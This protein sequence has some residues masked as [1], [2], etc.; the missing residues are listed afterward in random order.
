MISRLPK[1]VEYGA[2]LLAALAGTVNVIGLLGFEHQAVSHLS[3]MVTR[4]GADLLSLNGAAWHLTIIL[5]SFLAGSIISGF[6]IE[7]TA[8]K[9]GRNYSF[10]LT[11]EGGLLLLALF[12]LENGLSLGHYF[13]SAACGMQNALF[14]TYSGAILRTT[15]VTG[16]F[17][18]LGLMIG[19]RLRGGEFDKRKAGL[20]LLIIAGF[21]AGG[22]LGAG[23]YSFFRFNALL[24]P[25]ALALILAVVYWLYARGNPEKKSA[26]NSISS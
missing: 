12:A 6:A 1:W 15:H 19:Q 26:S 20:F 11:I 25:V 4:L 13:A 16:V 5:L 21:L 3:G 18:D 14:T 9:I 7:N 2:F 17:T 10:V 24:F 23:L 22:T 8:L